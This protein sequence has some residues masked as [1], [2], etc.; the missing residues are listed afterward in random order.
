[1]KS[2]WAAIIIFTLSTSAVFGFTY[3]GTRES[4]TLVLEA[5]AIM[6]EASETETITLHERLTAFAERF[7]DSERLLFL[8]VSEDELRAVKKALDKATAAAKIG[9]RGLLHVTLSELCDS[10]MNVY[11]AV[12][13]SLAG[14]I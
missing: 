5:T 9:D 14:I 12:C 8:S 13:F 3:F 1:M 4:E 11:D 10:L 7:E 2:F 6:Q